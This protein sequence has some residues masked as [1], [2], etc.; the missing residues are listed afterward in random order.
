MAINNSVKYQDFNFGTPIMAA[1]LN[2]V[3][4]LAYNGSANGSIN[5]IACRVVSSVAALRQVTGVVAGYVQTAGYYKAGDGGGALYYQPAQTGQSDNGGTI[6]V[7]NDGTRWEM[8]DQ[9][10]MNVRQWGARGDRSGNDDGSIN[11]AVTWCIAN[12]TGTLFFPQGTYQL[13]TGIT[14]DQSG[15]TIGALTH[16][17]L[18]GAGQGATQLWFTGT[19]DCIHYLGSAPNGLNSYFKISDMQ[20]VGAVGA[21]QGNGLNIT[22]ASVFTM[23]DVTIR[24]LANGVLFVDL[25]QS[26]FDNCTIGGC[27]T[28][29]TGS[30]STFS[31]P[32][33]IQ[34]LNCDIVSN[35][36]YG[37]SLTDPTT[38]LFNGGAVQGNGIGGVLA[39]KYGVGLFCN[40]SNPGG[41]NGAASATFISTYFEDNTTIADI[42]MTAGNGTDGSTSFTAKGCTFNRI[43]G[44]NFVTNNVRVDI[45]AANT[46][47]MMLDGNGF[48]GFNT[49]VA[50]SGRPYV[51]INPSGGSVYNVTD[52]GNL[53]GASVEKP[54]FI[55][56]VESASGLASA[57]CTFNGVSGTLIR[58]YNV[59]GITK[60][61]TGDYTVTF[62]KQGPFVNYPI[63]YGLNGVGFAS[64]VS[65]AQA[66][67][68]VQ[69]FLADGVTAHD[70]S[71]ISVVA[72]GNND[73]T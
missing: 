32:N 26:I 18:V 6:I 28:G 12:G 43:S 65:A 41:L 55:G 25:L 40:N 30:Y 9:T 21:T 64:T 66:N 56:P 14:V 7:A 10:R 51:Q 67:L 31:P 4:S 2:D 3:D 19:G 37:V 70:F 29:I 49:Y 27:S 42:W 57:Y 61:S 44:T 71:Q 20:I 73:V 36:N 54:T 38:V 13:A 39:N 50:S 24:N 5:G 58:G 59:G 46:V 8:A 52:W 15:L 45:G 16:I 11:A 68:R 17:N 53:Y 33:D 1:W 60:N 23:R 22:L 47:K 35:L 62:Q 34:F 63:V 72:Y 69:T 48:Q